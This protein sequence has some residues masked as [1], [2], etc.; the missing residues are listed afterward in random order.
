MSMTFLYHHSKMS[1][2]KSLNNRNK[3]NSNSKLRNSKLQYKFSCWIK[4][5]HEKSIFGVQFNQHLNGQHNY[6]ATV[7]SNRISIYKCLENG[8]IQLVQCYADPDKDESFYTCA[9]SFDDITGLPILAAA[10]ARG[11]IRMISTSLMKSF[12]H[13]TGHGNSINDLKISPIDQNLLLSVSKDHSLRLW[14]IKTDQCVVIFGGIE[15][16]RD[17]VLSADFHLRGHKVISC[18]MD[19]SL[20]IWSLDDQTIENAVADSYSYNPTKTNKPFHCV[21]QQFPCFTTRDIHTNYVDCVRWFGNFVFS[22]SCENAIV[23]WKP[24]KLDDEND[25]KLHK[26]YP[27]EASSTLIHRFEYKECDIW[28]MRFS[29][30]SKQKKMALGNQKGKTYIW[31]ID[32]DDLTHSK[33]VRF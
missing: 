27:S 30:D 29:M 18:G 4:E 8:Q 31:D 28:F 11:I 5:D 22:K 24:G 9:W 17:E 19:H 23:C 6:F 16:H 10:G 32:T 3:S 33:Y 21:K 20:K 1:K 26:S 13:Y 14:N 2:T 7:G 25:I 15:G 12:K